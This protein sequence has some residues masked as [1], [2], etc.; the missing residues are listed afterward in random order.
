MA[1]KWYDACEVCKGK[2]FYQAGAAVFDCK[3][4]ALAQ[5][6]IKELETSGGCCLALYRAGGGQTDGRP[7]PYHSEEAA[8]ERL[9]KKIGLV[10]VL[11]IDGK[12]FPLEGECTRT[13]GCRMEAGHD[14]D[15][16]TNG[17]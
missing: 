17:D 12:S 7:C 10:G 15:C 3:H 13:Y 5:E 9:T 16:A 6:L 14:C 8:K 2:G 4:I 1:A 11:E